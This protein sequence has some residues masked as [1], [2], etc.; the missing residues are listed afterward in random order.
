MELVWQL[1]VNGLV[2]GS[3]YALVAYGF[4]LVFWITRT[5]HFA[6]GAV[7]ASAGYAAY[8]VH[9][10]LHPPLAVTILAAMLWS[11][12][13]GLAVEALFYR[14][15]RRAQATPL[16]IL[17]TSVGLLIAGE[18]LL[19]LAFGP[20]HRTLAS[21]DV[22]RG[23]NVLG[24]YI[25]PPQAMMIGS[26]LLLLA[27]LQLFLRATRHGRTLRAVADNPDMAGTVGIDLSRV[28]LLTVAIASALAAPGAVLTALDKG[29]TPDMGLMMILLASIAVIVGGVSS[30]AGVALGAGL[31][32]LA[33]NLGIWRLP[34]E[35]Q[36]GMAFSILL[37]FILFRPR[38]FFGQKLA[39]QEF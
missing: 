37:V 17:V 34:S 33:Q 28:Y 13:L 27:M 12:A 10:T 32:G 30:M 6:H 16:T 36:D 20:E 7:Y 9:T 25:T 39:R 11:A 1:V 21:T 15:L 38:G 23:W 14:P 29:V 31:L 18:N 4:G 35:W 22:Q 24:A 19:S 8:V 26:A 3:A 5:F 2:V